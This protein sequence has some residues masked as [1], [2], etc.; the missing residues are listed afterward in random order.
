MERIDLDNM[1][2]AFGNRVARLRKLQGLSQ[3]QL[4]LNAG[5]D[6]TY[7]ASVEAGRRNVSLKSIVRLAH[8]L[9]VTPDVLFQE[10]DRNER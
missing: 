4:A 10:L 6:R 8:G 7:V 3:E 1:Q 5:L 9:S 2:L